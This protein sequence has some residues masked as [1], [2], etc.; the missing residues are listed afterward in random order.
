M[1]RRVAAAAAG[2]DSAVGHSRKDQNRLTHRISDTPTVEAAVQAQPHETAILES[3]PARIFSCCS[4]IYFAISRPSCERR[5]SSFL[6][7]LR[8]N[9]VVL[10]SFE[11]FV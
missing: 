1:R 2:T 3:F 5:G 4:K 11:A 6:R 9:V 10:R 7:G 8:V